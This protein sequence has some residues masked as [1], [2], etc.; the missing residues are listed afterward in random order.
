MQGWKRN[1]VIIG[2]LVLIVA[3]GAT[4]VLADLDTAGQ[5]ASVIG[6]VIGVVGLL[7]TLLNAPGGADAVRRAV[8]TGRAV[9]TGGGRANTGVASSGGGQ[10]EDTGDARSHGGRANTGVSDGF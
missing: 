10:A 3:M 5:V 1:A 4:W 2:C 6:C 8:H 9:T 7:F